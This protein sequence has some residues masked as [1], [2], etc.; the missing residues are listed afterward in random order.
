MLSMAA[1]LTLKYCRSTFFMWCY[2]VL[3]NYLLQFEVQL[4]F[5]MR[6]E[7][8]AELFEW[9]TFTRDYFESSHNVKHHCY[10]HLIY[11]QQINGFL[12]IGLSNKMHSKYMRETSTYILLAEV[13]TRTKRQNALCTLYRNQP[14]T[15]FNIHEYIYI[16]IH[17]YITSYLN[18]QKYMRFSYRNYKTYRTR[19]L[20]KP[21][22]M[23][24]IPKR[25]SAM[26]AITEIIFHVGTLIF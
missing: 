3:L 6:E 10:H 25:Y 23:G 18:F 5:G 12:W 4:A 14:N 21:T 22:T 16:C 1:S 15:W 8:L 24:K 7:M 2:I 13:K 20:K 9:D 19:L 17:I 26:T 11:V